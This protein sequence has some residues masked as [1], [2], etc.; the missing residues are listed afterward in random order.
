MVAANLEIIGNLCAYILGY[1]IEFRSA[2]LVRMA[3]TL[4]IL[5]AF[6]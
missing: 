3:P 6:A 4:Q 2:V 1:Y 5:E